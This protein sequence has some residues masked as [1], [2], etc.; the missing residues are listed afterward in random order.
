[1]SIK[2]GLIYKEIL[3]VKVNS[4][5]VSEV[6][7]FIRTCHKTKQKLFIVTPNPE[8]LVEAYVNS[9]FLQVLN[10]ADVAIPDGVGLIWAG[11]FLGK[12]LGERV[13]GVDLMLELCRMAKEENLKIFLLGGRPGVAEKAS[14]KIIDKFQLKNDQMAFYEGAG[15]IRQESEKEREDVINKINKFRPDFLFVA[16]GAPFQERWIYNSIGKLRVGLAMAVGGS[17]D[18]LAGRL[19]RAPVLVRKM[20]FEWLWRLFHEPWRW[21]RQVKL[22]KFLW[23]IIREKIEIS[24]KKF[25]IPNCK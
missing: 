16:Y 19:C 11:K 24:N 22:F 1:M 18:Y 7:N 3:G 5:Q 2:K 20:G 17:L 10:K 12:K 4:T 15:D 8:Q 9:N 14:R 13:S 6:L 23:L 21:R 25:Q